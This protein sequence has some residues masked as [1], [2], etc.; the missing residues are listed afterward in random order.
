M[1][2]T[3]GVTSRIVTSPVSPFSHLSNATAPIQYVCPSTS[4]SSPIE[5]MIVMFVSQ[6]GT[7]ADSW[8]ES[9]LVGSVLL[10]GSSG[11]M[12]TTTNAQSDATEFSQPICTRPPSSFG[13]SS[14]QTPFNLGGGTPSSIPPVGTTGPI[15]VA[16]TKSSCPASSTQVKAN[17]CGFPASSAMILVLPT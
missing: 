5:S 13:T 9:T 16:L 11:I 2:L 8:K 17:Q 10:F 15:T 6:S 7:I 12:Y 4:E 3:K 14:A 1:L